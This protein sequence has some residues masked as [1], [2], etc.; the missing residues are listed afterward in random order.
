[1]GALRVRLEAPLERRAELDRVDGEPLSVTQSRLRDQ[2]AQQHASLTGMYG[3]DEAPAFHL[4]LD[5][6]AMPADR[7]VE[8]ILAAVPRDDREASATGGRPVPAMAG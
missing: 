4:I 7:V 6:T 3:V 1:R 2:D 5:P 8:L